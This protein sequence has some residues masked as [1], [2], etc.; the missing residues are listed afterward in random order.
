MSQEQ[1]KV[2]EQGQ[3]GEAPA[4]VDNLF[5]MKLLVISLGVILI[6]CAITFFALLFMK[7]TKKK[8]VVATPIEMSVVVAPDETLENVTVNG[9]E[10]ILHIEGEEGARIVIVNPYTAQEKAIVKLD[11][12]PQ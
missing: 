3:N 9:R 8:E 5:A 6:V 11:K 2:E 4:P 7:G 10:L 1:V 12:A